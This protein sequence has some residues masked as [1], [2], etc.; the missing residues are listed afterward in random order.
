MTNIN[1]CWWATVS[2]GFNHFR[3]SNPYTLCNKTSTLIKWLP[4][5]MVAKLKGLEW[6][7]WPSGFSQQFKSGWWGVSNELQLLT[8]KPYFP[9]YMIPNNVLCFNTKYLHLML[10]LASIP[11]STI[12]LVCVSSKTSKS[13]YYHNLTN[14]LN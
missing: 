10:S 8:W 2:E 6:L 11:Q 3:G 4:C 1:Q 14:I 7:F 13:N 9:C 12:C 5:P